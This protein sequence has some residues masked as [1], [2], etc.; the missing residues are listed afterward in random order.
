[1]KK[2]MKGLLKKAKKEMKKT[3]NTEKDIAYPE[4]KLR[5]TIEEA[6]NGYIVSTGYDR[7]TFVAEGVEE[8]LS[9]VEELL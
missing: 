3:S 6:E 5:I 1:M 8:V 2:E 7:S 9:I 4:P